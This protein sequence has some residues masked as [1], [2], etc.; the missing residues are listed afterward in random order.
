M[1]LLGATIDKLSWVNCIL[2]STLIH[3]FSRNYKSDQNNFSCCFSK[4]SKGNGSEIVLISAL[5]IIIPIHGHG[6]FIILSTSSELV[7]LSC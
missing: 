1:L 3:P 7:K 5:N 6:V 2:L 4:N